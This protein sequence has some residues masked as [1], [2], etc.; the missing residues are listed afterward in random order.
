MEQTNI[1]TKDDYFT[2]IQLKRSTVELLKKHGGDYK[3]YDIFLKRILKG[4]VN[5]DRE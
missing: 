1:E 3:S 4:D 5:G 2:T